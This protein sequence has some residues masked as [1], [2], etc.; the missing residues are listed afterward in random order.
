MRENLVRTLTFTLLFVTTAL[1]FSAAAEAQPESPTVVG[2][3]G[4][5]TLGDGRAEVH[6][7]ETVAKGAT[8]RGEK[9][10]HIVFQCQRALFDNQSC[11]AADCQIHACAKESASTSKDRVPA[12]LSATLN[13]ISRNPDRFITAVTRG[14]GPE[15]WEAVVEVRAGKV[16]L[17]PLLTGL[18]QGAYRLK[19]TNLP[20]GAS[21]VAEHAIAWSPGA[22]A[23]FAVPGIKPGVYG[24]LVTEGPGETQGSEAWLLVAS[25]PA[26]P[27]Q[28][29][30]WEQVKVLI[31]PWRDDVE[32]PYL[33]AF[34][35]ATLVSLLETSPSNLPNNPA[36][37]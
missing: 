20:Q 27:Q 24:M 21:F 35:R 9:G 6:F 26:A 37:Q 8:L 5:W 29:A 13:L 28:L 19:L 4:R 15:P 32:T 12:W 18:P 33:H 36:G 1:R 11:P 30:S 25:G 22:T 31:A 10:G 14:L 16:N 34:L 3:S 7:G 23:D 2:L 17:A